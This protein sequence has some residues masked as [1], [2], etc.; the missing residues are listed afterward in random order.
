MWG[1]HSVA[2]GVKNAAGIASVRGAGCADQPCATT[3]RY[4]ARMM[5]SSGVPGASRVT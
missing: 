1:Y 4:Y 2:A 3:I 5:L